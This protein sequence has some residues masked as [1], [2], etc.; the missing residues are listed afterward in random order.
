[1]YSFDFEPGSGILTVTLH[2]YWTLA[3]AERFTAELANHIEDARRSAGALKMLLDFSK[4]G[5]QTS[6]VGQC[7]SQKQ[8]EAPKHASDKVALC[9]PA[10]FTRSLA[11]R[12][13]AGQGSRIFSSV[14]AA[15]AWLQDRSAT[16]ASAA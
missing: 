10:A 9:L 14:G 16:Q 4:H 7:M 11:E 13:S 2:G 15:R 6:E 1:M 12:Q 5:T 3:V 8:R